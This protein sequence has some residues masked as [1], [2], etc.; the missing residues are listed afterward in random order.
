ML[1]VIGFFLTFAL[2]GSLERS[3][4]QRE[5][6]RGMNAGLPLEEAAGSLVRVVRGANRSAGVGL[7]ALLIGLALFATGNE[8]AQAFVQA[9]ACAFGLAVGLG[10]GLFERSA[11]QEE[12]SS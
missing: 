11:A 10:G 8:P 4:A 1:E 9:S 3:K 5:M 12:L 7:I 2:G 6:Q